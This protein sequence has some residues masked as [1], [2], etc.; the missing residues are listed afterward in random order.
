MND[1]IKLE[2]YKGKESN[3]LKKNW[4]MMYAK[5]MRISHPT[6]R[7]GYESIEWGN[8]KVCKRC[9]HKHCQCRN[10]GRR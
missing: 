10:K 9:W 5:G 1:I 8:L 4:S 3:G 6:Y 7:K 2:S